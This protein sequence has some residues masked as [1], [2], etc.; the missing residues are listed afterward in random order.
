MKSA[1]QIFYVNNF[2]LIRLVTALLVLVNHSFAH[3]QLPV[4]GWYS[5]IQQFQPVPMFFVMSGFLLSASLERNSNLRQYLTNRFT[6][7]FPGLWAC[8]LLTVIAL[9][10]LREV[11]FFHV[12]AVPWLIAQMVGFIYTPSFFHQFGYGSYNGSLWTLVVE[13]Q[14]Y[15]ILPV[16]YITYKRLGMQSNRYFLVLFVISVAVA[17]LLRLP[18]LSAITGSTVQKVAR[19]SLFSHAYLFLAGV[20]IQRYKLYE[21]AFMY[22]KA[23][24]WAAAFLIFTNFVTPSHFWYVIAMLILACFTVSLAYTLPGVATR[25]LGKRDIS[26]G[27]FLYHGLPLSLLVEWEL[28][29]NIWYMVLVAT[30]TILLAWFSFRYVET[31][32]MAWAKRR[33]AELK[34]RQQKPLPIVNIDFSPGSV[35]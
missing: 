7:I 8:V 17:F 28:S 9:A 13:L 24:Y 32:A 10:M 1:N 22:G 26:Y 34:L 4:P 2:D 15:L 33:N 35:K 11:N 21:S 23:I 20:L 18:H 12:E 19:Y 5:I 16:I 3:L 30:V 31:P 29:G 25:W 27:V 6:R 14:F